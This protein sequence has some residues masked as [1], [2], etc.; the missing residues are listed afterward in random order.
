MEN[1]KERFGEIK[2]NASELDNSD[3]G[4]YFMIC[5]TVG[6]V[7][8]FAE[9]WWGWIPQWYIWSVCFILGCLFLFCVLIFDC[10]Q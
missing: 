6:T 4:F 3:L 10:K 9:V 8:F 7:E 5:F 1:I 2:H